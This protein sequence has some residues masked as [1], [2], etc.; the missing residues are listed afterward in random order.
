MERQSFIRRAVVP[1]ATVLM[2]MV[3]SLVLYNQSWRIGSDALHQLTAYVSGLILF[4]SIGFGPLY[5]YPKAFFRG[6]SALERVLVCLV[7]PVAWDVKE[8]LR[9]SEYFSWGESL[10]YG[11]N[12][13]FL[14]CLCVVATQMGICEMVCRWVRNRQVPDPVAVVSPATLIPVILGLAGV[15]IFFLWGGGASSFY[16]YQEGYKALF[17]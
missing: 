17:M 1:A 16:L 11:L 8:I 3:G 9:V 12:T 2:A 5:V 13:I 7:T 14:L 15:G 6:A 10:Y 4:V